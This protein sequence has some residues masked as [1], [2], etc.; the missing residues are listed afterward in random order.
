MSKKD[1]KDNKARKSENPVTPPQV[2]S[3]AVIEPPP[4]PVVQHPRT[5]EPVAVVVPVSHD[6]VAVLSTPVEED[7]L[8]ARH[9]LFTVEP[10]ESRCPILQHMVTV[11]LSRDRYPSLFLA[12]AAGVDGLLL[13]NNDQADK[14]KKKKKKPVASASP[15]PTESPTPAAVSPARVRKSAEEAQHMIDEH[16][17]A[18]QRLR[19]KQKER[20]RRK[21]ERELL[22]IE[23][24]ADAMKRLEEE[25]RQKR[26]EEIR[27]RIDI[28]QQRKEQRQIDHEL[29]MQRVRGVLNRPSKLEVLEEKYV[30]Q[31][32]EEEARQ[33]AIL[34][35]K[36]AKAHIPITEGLDDVQK[37]LRQVRE[38][39]K[40]REA[41]MKEH[42]REVERQHHIPH[43][44]RAY[45][46][47]MQEFVK[48][49]HGFDDDRHQKL[50]KQTKMAE[51]G[52]V[53]GQMAR[54]QQER[55]QER[56]N[57]SN[58]MSE[59]R[60]LSH[61]DEASTGHAG[62]LSHEERSKL[63]QHYLREWGWRRLPP[64]LKLQP[65]SAPTPGELQR[66]AEYEFV[67]QR[68]SK[69]LEYLRQLREQA[70]LVRNK[71]PKESFD[72]SAVVQEIK[73]LRV[74]TN[75]L[76]RKILYGNVS[77]DPSGTNG[78]D[79]NGLTSSSSETTNHP[80]KAR[81]SHI[82]FEDNDTPE[83]TER[84]RGAN[85]GE[86]STSYIDVVYAKIEMLRK[87]EEL[88]KRAKQDDSKW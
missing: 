71:K 67:K 64:G 41:E 20:D 54:I 27:Q 25:Q 46:E 70:D 16:A 9:T 19:D 44:G 13:N 75:L 29:S 58:N 31:Q 63:G 57:S 5:P 52:K 21:L 26:E 87:L 37:L 55:S 24:E 76:E 72:K 59:P 68:E 36:K 12:T 74:Q 80:R 1:A 69:G 35:E 30:A 40:I 51:Y 60:R 22:R 8:L 82:H 65:L 34:A 28:I 33:A 66:K 84:G 56:S 18:V 7:A 50:Y 73:N 78:S 42:I 3:A 81:E 2:K 48:A 79:K 23:E 86:D 43:Q 61:G 85:G 39:A 62:Q 45:D 77:K 53:V 88:R 4:P 10:F 38:R 47:A 17:K 14:P 49:R 32:K 15:P 11:L 83:N 6:P